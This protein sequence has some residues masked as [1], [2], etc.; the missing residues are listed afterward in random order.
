[1]YSFPGRVRLVQTKNFLCSV[2]WGGCVE[3]F[4]ADPANAVGPFGHALDVFDH[5][6]ESDGAA[7]AHHLR[8]RGVPHPAAAE[9]RQEVQEH[10]GLAGLSS[11][12]SSEQQ[13]ALWRVWRG[14]LI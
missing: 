12:A 4:V 9:R 11:L 1:M 7:A 5:D 13:T 10:L 2:R 3:Q 8:R 14:L 6:E